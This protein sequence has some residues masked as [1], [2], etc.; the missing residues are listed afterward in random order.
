MKPGPIWMMTKKPFIVLCPEG[1]GLL[2]ISSLISV[3]NKFKSN[4]ESLKNVFGDILLSDMPQEDILQM[5]SYTEKLDKSLRSCLKE[6]SILDSDSRNTESLELWTDVHVYEYENAILLMD[7]PPLVNSSYRFKEYGLSK[8][9]EIELFRW[10]HSHKMPDFE[11]ENRFLYIYKRYVSTPIDTVS[12]NDNW[13]MKR[14]TN[15]V[16]Q[17]IGFSD[18]PRFSEFFYT[19]VHSEFDGAELMLIRHNDLVLFSDYLISGTPVHPESGSFFTGKQVK[20]NSDDFPK[21]SFSSPVKSE[22]SQEESGFASTDPGGL[23][24]LTAKSS[25]EELPF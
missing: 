12:D 13:E 22:K 24:K 21:D 11:A 16:S 3:V 5:L 6:E 15:A 8:R 2:P 18:N 9:A 14:I 23:R 1:H 4:A 7:F 20:K 25:K 17:A 19:T 10:F